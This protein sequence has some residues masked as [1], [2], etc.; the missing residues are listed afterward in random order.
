M[1]RGGGVI[2]VRGSGLVHSSG[3][4]IGAKWWWFG[5]SKGVVRL[6]E[7]RDDGDL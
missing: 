3:G 2:G 4:V 6:L 7:P 5:W 1:N